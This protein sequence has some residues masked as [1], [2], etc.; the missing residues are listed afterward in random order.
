MTEHRAG[1]DLYPRLSVVAPEEEKKKKRERDILSR[2]VVKLHPS[3]KNKTPTVACPPVGCP[4]TSTRARQHESRASSIIYGRQGY[5][6][7][8]QSQYIPMRSYA[9]WFLE[10]HPGVCQLLLFLGG[11]V[12]GPPGLRLQAMH[13]V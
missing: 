1:R 7:T 9:T 8:N 12:L 2:K 4:G 5:Q 6:P 10:T 13:A 3:T 11:K